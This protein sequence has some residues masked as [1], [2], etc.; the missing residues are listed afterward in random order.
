MKLLQNPKLRSYCCKNASFE[1]ES[2][3][4]TNWN[5]MHC[6]LSKSH[7]KVSKDE[8]NKIMKRFRSKKLKS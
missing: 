8:D 2:V 5:L 7:T 3:Q 4:N 6:L 1:D